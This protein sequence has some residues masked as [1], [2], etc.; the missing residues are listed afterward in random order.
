MGMVSCLLLVLAGARTLSIKPKLEM[1]E[2][3]NR[4]SEPC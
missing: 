1:G 3:R 2:A 4:S